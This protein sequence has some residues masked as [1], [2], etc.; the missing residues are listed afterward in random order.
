M[1][2]RRR[3]QSV[4]IL[5]LLRKGSQ[6]EGMRM[7]EYHIN[8]SKQCEKD[9]IITINS[10]IVP[11]CMPMVHILT[12]RKSIVRY[13]PIAESGMLLTDCGYWIQMR[14]CPYCG[15]RVRSDDAKKSNSKSEDNLYEYSPLR[16]RA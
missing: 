16:G 1:L 5:S 2:V 8:I 6:K 14:Y 4:E 15:Q 7:A 11:C 13:D 10:P 12:E 3:L 9:E